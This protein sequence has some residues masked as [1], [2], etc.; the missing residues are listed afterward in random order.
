MRVPR[1]LLSSAAI[2][3]CLSLPAAAEPTIAE[4]DQ[5]IRAL[6]AS[7]QT[8]TQLLQAQQAAPAASVASTES[9]GATAATPSAYQMGA[10]YLDVFTQKFSRDEYRSMRNDP[11]KLPNGPKG[12]PN[13]SAI[14]AAPEEFSYGGF[15]AESSL[16]GFQKAD[17]LVSVQWSGSFFVDQPGDHTFSLNLKKQANFGVFGCRSV[18]RVSDEVVADVMGYYG[19]N[20]KEQIDTAQST[21]TLTSGV[22]NFSL[23]TSCLREDDRAFDLIATT[24]SLA[25]P[26]DRAPK[27]IP[28]ER[29]GVQP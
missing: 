10:L 20:G 24:I 3:C 15:S 6:E 9:S 16:A 23:W 4:L 8:L 14:I 5:R 13:G 19:G 17:A 28:P 21:K 22:Y 29:F 11:A 27:P 18:L 1:F 26:G 25:A 2:A 12:V 7:V